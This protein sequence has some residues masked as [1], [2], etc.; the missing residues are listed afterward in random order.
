MRSK[1]TLEYCCNTLPYTGV[2][3]NDSITMKGLVT[4]FPVRYA[5][6]RMY[7]TGRK[8]TPGSA[9]TVNTAGIPSNTVREKRNSSPVS[10]HNIL[11]CIPDFLHRFI[12]RVPHRAEHC[13][14]KG[15]GDLQDPGKL[16]WVKATHRAGIKTEGFCTV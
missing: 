14:D 9:G 11:L 8:R 10:E 15:R 5:V 3:W 12:S 16:F 2:P 4:A 1:R 13:R 7:T 6:I